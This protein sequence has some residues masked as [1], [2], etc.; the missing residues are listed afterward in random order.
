MHLM[1]IYR[2]CHALNLIGFGRFSLVATAS[3]SIADFSRRA[4]QRDARSNSDLDVLD[5]MKA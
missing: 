2:L 3:P 1:Q 5:V 4:V